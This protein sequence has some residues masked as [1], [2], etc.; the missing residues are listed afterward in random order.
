MESEELTATQNQ[1]LSGGKYILI[2]DPSYSGCSAV[3]STYCVRVRTYS[4]VESLNL[5][6]VLFIFKILGMLQTNLI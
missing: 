6:T 1:V 4:V 3:T 5:K 2:A